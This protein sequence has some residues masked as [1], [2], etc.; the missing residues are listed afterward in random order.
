M[1]PQVRRGQLKCGL[2]LLGSGTLKNGDAHRISLVE[3]QK[4]NP[5]LVKRTS[6]E[7]QRWDLG[8]TGKE[9]PSL[10]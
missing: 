9:T 1:N 2:Y 7:M 3:S 6:R 5:A 8:Y 10:V 4:Y